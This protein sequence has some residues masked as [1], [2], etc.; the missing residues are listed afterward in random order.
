[1]KAIFT[2]FNKCLRC[3]ILRKCNPEGYCKKCNDYL[4]R[5]RIQDALPL[6]KC[7]CLNPDCKK[8]I[9]I[10][11]LKGTPNKYAIGHNI[12]G[13]RGWSYKG[14]FKANGYWRLLK[15]HYPFSNPRGNVYEHRY[16]MYIYL[17]ILNNKV[18]YLPKGYDV[19][20]KNGNKLDNRIENLELIQSS[21]HSVVHQ[22]DGNYIPIDGRT[23]YDCGSEYTQEYWSRVDYLIGKYRCNLC[24]KKYYYKSKQELKG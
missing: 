23:C 20:H 7:E 15:K 2:I 3:D 19:H 10:K 16:I 18:T 13:K 8:M 6:K 21:T 9:P 11:T 14:R 22:N 4:V 17:S 12:A 1:M 5:K 24:N